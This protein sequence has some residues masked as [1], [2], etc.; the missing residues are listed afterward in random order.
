MDATLNKVLIADAILKE[1]EHSI[2]ALAQRHSNEYGVDAFDANYGQA[3]RYYILFTHEVS[4]L[5][6]ELSQPFT[7]YNQYFWY[8][9]FKKAYVA[10]HGFDAGMEQQAFTLLEAAVENA[11]YEVDLLTIEAIEHELEAN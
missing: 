9:M 7:F 8:L 11:D 10:K 6:F 1:K 5:G 3:F 2:N 4:L